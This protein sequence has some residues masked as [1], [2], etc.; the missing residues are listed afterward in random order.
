MTANA[1]HSDDNLLELI[2]TKERELEAQVAQ[3]RE[4]ARRLVE[5]AQ[6]AAAARQEQARREAAALAERMQAESAQ[7]AAAMAAQRAEAAKIEADRV[8]ARAVELTVKR[9]LDG[10][11]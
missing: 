7:E 11:E 1:G 6:A 4:Q 8:R 2:A 10:L 9:V 3:A 5:S